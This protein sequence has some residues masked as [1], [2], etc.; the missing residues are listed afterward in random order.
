MGVAAAIM[1]LQRNTGFPDMLYIPRIFSLGIAQQLHILPVSLV[2]PAAITITGQAI[3][4]AR[5]VSTSSA[6]KR[7]TTPN[8]TAKI[9]IIE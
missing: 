4:T 7:N 3:A 5:A 1:R 2:R 6:P 9:G 8:A